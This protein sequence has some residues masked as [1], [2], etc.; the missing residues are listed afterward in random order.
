MRNAHRGRDACGPGSL[1]S[2]LMSSGNIARAHIEGT[3]AIQ[4]VLET[5]FGDMPFES[6]HALKQKCTLATKMCQLR[7]P[8]RQ[9]TRMSCGET[10]CRLSKQGFP[11]TRY[12]KRRL[13][14]IRSVNCVCLEECTSFRLHVQGARPSTTQQRYA[15]CA[16]L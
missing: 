5:I 2:T 15:A 9:T 12:E 11:S 7:I 16:L 4:N 8:K 6:A 13:Q 3:L 1:Q 14:D 10:A